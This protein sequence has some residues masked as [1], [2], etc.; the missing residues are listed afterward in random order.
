MGVHFSGAFAFLLVAPACSLKSFSTSRPR[1]HLRLRGAPYDGLPL[2]LQA[3]ASFA[4]EATKFVAIPTF[5]PLNPGLFEPLES[6]LGSTGTLG[7][8]WASAKAAT[9]GFDW[10]A[11]P[12]L[13]PV[14]PGISEA[15]S[16]VDPPLRPLLAAPLAALAVLALGEQWDRIGTGGSGANDMLPFGPGQGEYNEAE[17]KAFY[18]ARPSVVVKRLVRLAA[19]TGGFNARLLLDFLMTPKGA[20]HWVNEKDRAAESL[21]LANKLGPTFIKLG[22]AA[23]YLRLFWHLRMVHQSDSLPHRTPLACALAFALT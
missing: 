13:P 17:A 18:G 12:S 8:A 1:L 23:R 22:Q 11:L 21:Q 15:V 9:E 20:E 3:L 16:S 2:D 10:G 14:N 7:S 19:L 6:F 5:P 4:H